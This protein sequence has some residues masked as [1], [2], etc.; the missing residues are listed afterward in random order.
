MYGFVHFLVEAVPIVHKLVFISSP[1][2]KFSLSMSLHFTIVNSQT[3]FILILLDSAMFMVLPVFVFLPLNSYLNSLAL[4][5]L[6]ASR[7]KLLL[8]PAIPHVTNAYRFPSGTVINVIC[9]NLEALGVCVIH[10]LYRNVMEQRILSVTKKG[11]CILKVKFVAFI[12]T[13]LR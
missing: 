9:L 1:A 5:F 6:P 13:A 3:L 12:S 7:N 4:N 10:I 11:W 2:N 8:S